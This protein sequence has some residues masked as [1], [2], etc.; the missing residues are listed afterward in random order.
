MSK[1]GIKIDPN[2]VLAIQNLSLPLSK[3]I[4]NSFFGKVNF[5]R[6]FVPDFAE[7]TRHIVEM[8]KDKTI[9]HWN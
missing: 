4:I 9:F 1:E 3:T 6:R 8:M 5:L 2:R 7:L